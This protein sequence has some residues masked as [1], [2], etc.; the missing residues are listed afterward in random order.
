M[1]TCNSPSL[2]ICS[3]LCVAV[4][5]VVQRHVDTKRK[6][7]DLTSYSRFF[8]KRV[9]DVTTEMKSLPCQELP[10]LD[11]ILPEEGRHQLMPLNF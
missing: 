5:T 6:R 10:Q 8:G 4:P 1:I 11:R 9:T 3:P 7:S 2:M